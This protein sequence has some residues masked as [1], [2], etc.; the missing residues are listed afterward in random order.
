MTLSHDS[1]LRGRLILIAGGTS[2]SGS[3]AARSLIQAGARVVVAGRDELKLLRMRASIPGVITAHVDLADEHQTFDFADRVR[4]EHG[5]VD[6]VL[7]L[8]GGWRG[9]GG[10][11]GQRDEDFRVLEGS[12]SALRHVS[13]AFDEDL[14]F[15]DAG[16][17]AIVSS[18]AVQSPSAGGANYASVKA[19]SEIWLRAVA[20]GFAAHARETGS[21]SARAVIFRVRAL[22]GLEAVLANEFMALWDAD[23]SEEGVRE[24]ELVA[25]KQ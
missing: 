13:R 10:L 21:A 22:V 3:I 14:R 18:T 2:A 12:L 7:H 4:E 23:A 5:R 9:G 11:A 17:A 25:S 6:G 8:V 1:A 19:A 24:I 16:R 15:S 20:S